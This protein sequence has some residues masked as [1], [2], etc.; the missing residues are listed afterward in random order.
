MPL[1]PSTLLVTMLLVIL[2]TSTSYVVVWLQDRREMAL[3][4]M[5]ASALLGATF[6]ATRVLLPPAPAITLANPGVFAGIGCTWMACRV[7]CGRPPLPWVLLIPV[8]IW[9]GLCSIPGFL[10]QTELRLAAANLIAAA[11]FG[12]AIRELWRLD[13]GNLVARWWV[14]GILAA[15]GAGCLVRGIVALLSPV[16]RETDI[17]V[18]HGFTLMALTAM[19]FMLLMSFGMIALVKERSDRR[20]K[21]AAVVDALT[22]LG[23]R[24]H[25]NESLAQA[26]HEARRGRKP[27]AVVMIDA[28]SFKTY[29]D[30][31]GHPQG[32]VC[33]RAIAGALRGGLV[34]RDDLV[35]RYGGEEFVVL[36][37]DTDATAAMRIA[38]RL[39]IA[40]WS[41]GLR[42][43]GR[44][45]G[46]VTI[47]LGVAALDQEQKIANGPDLLEAADQALYRAK[48]LGRNCTVCYSEPVAE[49]LPSPRLR[50]VSDG[51]PRA[52]RGALPSD[53]A[54]AKAPGVAPVPGEVVGGITAATPAEQTGLGLPG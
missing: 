19:G 23:N 40:V 32:D 42:H 6:F 27:L 12:L 38:E 44:E 54:A 30:L 49:E 9:L 21:Q 15:Q 29:N 20:Y 34:R 36:L 33:L 16:S 43:G 35:L 8:A 52:E 45:E 14:F 31:Y 7:I 13:E 10:M 41:L 25:L 51:P 22:G 37:P 2:L 18:I 28:D 1:D 39:R 11:L 26:V 4:W 17:E 46:V 3:L 50:L 48:R 53:R 5:T 47:S 24:R